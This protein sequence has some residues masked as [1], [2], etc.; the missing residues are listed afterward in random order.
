MLDCLP[1][2]VAVSPD[3]P[4]LKKEAEARQNVHEVSR[5]LKL[6]VSV[7]LCWVV[8]GISEQQKCSYRQ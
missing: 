4:Y 8:E 6:P 5:T 2:G 3:A 7:P 1:A